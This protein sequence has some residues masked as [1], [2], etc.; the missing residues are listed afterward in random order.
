VVG[1]DPRGVGRSAGVDCLTDAQLDKWIAADSDP[2]T[3][4]EQDRLMADAKAFGKA[5]Q[6]RSGGVLPYLGTESVV[7]DMDVLRAALGEERLNYL[8]FSYGTMLGALYADEFGPTTGR[9]V[10]D[11]VLPP[12]LTSSEIAEGQAKGFE[13]ALRRYVADCQQKSDCPVAGDSVDAG[14]SKIQGLLTGLADKPLPAGNGEQLTQPLAAGAILYYLY[15]PSAGD[16]DSLSKGL[17][18]AFAGD[19]STLL[20]LY[21][22][23]LERNPDGSYRNNSQEAFF[24]VTCLDRE[25]DSTEAELA[26][27]ADQWAQEAPTFGRY[28]AWSEAAC[29]E[30]PVPGQG[31]TRQV[32]A[33]EAGPIVVIG[34]TH[35]PATPL[36]WAQR[37]A[38][39]LADAHLI[40]WDS[41][42]HTAY[43]NGSQC[44]QDAVDAYLVDGTLPAPDLV[45]D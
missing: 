43:G 7:K 23:R 25:S 4:A 26:A 36:P 24:A 11:G 29:A 22:T 33:A 18:D 35:D 2:A 8:G 5:C 38:E 9:M 3:P 42:G 31:E 12:S 16:W 14:V 34:N 41:D 17:T 30:W 19:G 13:D 28:L 44:V 40:V 37:L 45:C 6:K 1:F 10:L 27:R 39:N 15:F 21:R 20:D 32:T